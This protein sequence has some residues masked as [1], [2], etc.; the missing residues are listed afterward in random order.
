MGDLGHKCLYI[1]LYGGYLYLFITI[2]QA[3]GFVEGLGEY[4]G[5]AMFLGFAFFL[6]ILPNG[7]IMMGFK[8]YYRHQD[9]KLDRELAD[10]NT[11]GF[12][13]VSKDFWNKK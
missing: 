5:W 12:I 9:K 6:L 11:T 8:E 2:E 1:L 13:M 3:T 4:G 10:P 7:L